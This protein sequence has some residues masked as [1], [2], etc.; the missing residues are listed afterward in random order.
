MLDG[1]D[2]RSKEQLSDKPRRPILGPTNTLSAPPAHSSPTEHPSADPPN[3]QRPEHGS[4][5]D[6]H[7]ARRDD[8]SAAPLWHDL[9]VRQPG[10]DRTADV[11]RLSRGLPL[12]TRAARS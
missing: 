11:P 10:L 2:F 12:R 8:R 3:F 6:L 4:E 7:R 9:R 1:N 5:G